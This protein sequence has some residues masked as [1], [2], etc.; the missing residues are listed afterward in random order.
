MASNV[1]EFHKTRKN[2]NKYLTDG[3]QP[4]QTKLQ[5]QPTDRTTTLPTEMNFSSDASLY[6]SKNASRMSTAK[7]QDVPK[8][9]K[10]KQA[11]PVEKKPEVSPKNKKAHKTVR[12]DLGDR[13]AEFG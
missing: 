12:I 8:P 9:A 3:K 13:E 10:K 2:V 11:T 7:R 5:V 4:G 6:T 1:W